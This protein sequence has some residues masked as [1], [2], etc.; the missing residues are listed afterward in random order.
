MCASAAKFFDDPGA[1]YLRRTWHAQRD[2]RYWTIFEA[3]FGS[4]RTAVPGFTGERCPFEGDHQQIMRNHA[5]ALGLVQAGEAAFAAFGL[6][7]HPDNHH[8]VEPW[9]R[10]RTIVADPSLLFRIPADQLIESAARQGT[11]WSDWADYMQERYMLEIDGPVH[12]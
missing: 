2:R 8:V 11:S 4:V 12:E 9:E 6:V 10:Y 1:C 7:H 5:L 3:A